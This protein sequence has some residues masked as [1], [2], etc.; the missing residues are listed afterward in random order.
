MDCSD[1]RGCGRRARGRHDRQ[2]ARGDGGAQSIQALLHTRL[3]W[4]G[5]CGPPTVVDERRM[6]TRS[7]CRESRKCRRLDVVGRG[8]TSSGR[9][10]LSMNTSP[11]K[12]Y[13]PGTGSPSHPYDACS[14]STQLVLVAVRPVEARRLYRGRPHKA[15]RQHSSP[16]CLITTVK[17]LSRIP[18]G[19]PIRRARPVERFGIRGTIP[20]S[21]DASL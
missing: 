17:W 6:N 4:A 7:T 5:H 16:S 20:L 12:S 21:R 11:V 10:G 2:G 8:R 14:Y 9:R 13:T 1:G 15:D 19:Y 18:S 3:R